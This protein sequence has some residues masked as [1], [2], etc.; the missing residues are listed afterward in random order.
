MRKKAMWIMITVGSLIADVY[1]DLVIG[2][3]LTI[4]IVI[5]SW[6]IAYKSGWMDGLD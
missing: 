5:A 4:P 3:L 6:W 1:F 2:L